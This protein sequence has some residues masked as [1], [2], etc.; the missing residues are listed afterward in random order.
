VEELITNSDSTAAKMVPK[1]ILAFLDK[2]RAHVLKK[3]NFRVVKIDD[4]QLWFETLD[5]FVSVRLL[6]RHQDMEIVY[7]VS[8][9]SFSLGYEVHL[10][11]EMLN[12]AEKL[13]L[14]AG[15]VG[16]WKYQE[17]VYE[18]WF[19]VLWIKIWARRNGFV[20][21]RRILR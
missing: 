19:I 12:S 18:L 9:H 14:I 7:D 6:V 2:E 3:W 17:S 20:A 16:G 21:K 8:L 10:K 11:E 4:S 13:D 5:G 1:S 15:A